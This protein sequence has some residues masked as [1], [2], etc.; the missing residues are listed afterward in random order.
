[1][2]HKYAGEQAL[3]GSGL[4]Y[5]VVRPGGLTNNTAGE[6]RLHAGN[7]LHI[8]THDA[9]SH[10]T[11]VLVTANPNGLLENNAASLKSLL[12]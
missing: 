3:T 4:S 6:V 2:D 7:C 1:M 12:Y 10:C 9:V 5:T 8:K 11:L